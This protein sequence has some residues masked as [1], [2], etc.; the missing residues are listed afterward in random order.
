VLRP[1]PTPL[2]PVDY[3]PVV[4]DAEGRLLRVFLNR[5][6]QWHLPPRPDQP[7][8]GRLETAVLCFEDRRFRVHPGVDPLAMARALRQALQAGRVVSG[9]STLTMQVARLLQPRPRTLPT[10]VLEMV[11]AL[12]LEAWRSKDEILRL[13]LDHAPYGANV[14]GYQAASWRYFGKEP[15]E[16]TWSE[17]ATLAVLPN[18]PGLISPLADPAALRAR[19]NEL[20][21]RLQAQGAFDQTTA[22][23]AALEPVPAGTRPFPLHAPHLAQALAAT[24]RG[25]IATTLSRPLQ[26]RAEELVRRHAHRL[27]PLGIGSAAALV[28]ETP[29]GAVRAYV[30]SPAF[31]DRQG[32]GQVDGVRAPRSPGSLLKPFLYALAIDEGLLLPQTLL[33]DVPTFFGAFAPQ[34]AEQRFDGLVRARDAL[35]RSLN[36]PAVR[37]LST[38]GLRPFYLF[39]QQAGLSTLFRRPEEYGLPLIIGGAEVTLWDA[40]ALYRGLALGGRFTPLQVCARPHAGP[41]GNPPAPAAGSATPALDGGLVSPGA[42]FLTL[43]VLREVRRPGAEYYWQQY[44][45]RRPLAWKTGTSYGQ[46]DAWAVGVDPQWTLAVWAGNFGGEG[47]ANLGGAQSAGPLLFDLL[48]A[49]PRGPAE[50]WFP[51][52]RAD[53]QPLTLCAQTGFAAG[54]HCPDRVQADAPRR[55]RPLRLCP[56]HRT[57]FVT[58]DERYQVCS[59]CWAGTLPR[60]VHR[61]LLPPDVA[62]HL[63]ERGQVAD[64]VPPH[65]PACPAQR[66]EQPV[67]VTYPA[68]Q[69]HLRVPRDLDGARQKLVLQAAHREAGSALFWYLDDAYLG[70]SQDRHVLAA[71]VPEGWHTLEVVDGAG[72][73]DRVHFHAQAGR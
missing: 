19:R 73:R 65:L 54:P 9:G 71:H 31:F 38:Y 17:A 72:R 40:A 62:Q 29:T 67:Q 33:P 1:L 43:E 46:R 26:Q 37:L 51:R 6:Q 63:R 5:R 25:W 47:N 2:F 35:I 45:D 32:Q 20:L 68:D 44:R 49:L 64:H 39:L 58:R 30:G 34:N 27:A 56:Y 66:G 11:L 41:A 28:A 14:V 18:A 21:G 24:D 60:P 53:L 57:L 69:A 16:L 4:T 7:V 52:P 8:P 36:V 3:C 10:K 13:Y 59:R 12:R 23:L 42:A 22:R 70:A 48:N 61:L 50:A 55:M 15:A